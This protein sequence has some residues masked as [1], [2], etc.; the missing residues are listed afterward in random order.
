VMECRESAR[1]AV[2]V[3]FNDQHAIGVSRQ[4]QAAVDSQI[5]VSKCLH[6]VLL[7]V[8]NLFDV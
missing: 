5:V 8:P 2:A 1:A 3:E 6:D 4:F 7:Y